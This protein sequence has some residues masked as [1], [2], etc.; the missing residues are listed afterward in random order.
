[1]AALTAD[2]V[3]EYKDWG[4]VSK[5]YPVNAASVIFKGSLVAIDTDGFARP[6]VDTAS[7]RVAGIAAESVTGGAAD[8]DVEVE[9]L[10]GILVLLPASSIAATDVPNIMFLVDDQTI[11]ETTPANSVKVGRLHEFVSATSGWVHIP[12]GGTTE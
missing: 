6:G 8:G 11:D 2:R 1:M 7:F 5:S 9:V 3:T 4:M 10:S 12:V